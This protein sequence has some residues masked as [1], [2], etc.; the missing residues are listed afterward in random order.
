MTIATQPPLTEFVRNKL[1]SLSPSHLEIHDDSHQHIG[2][3]EAKAGA[4][5]RVVIV[6]DAFADMP[7]L[8]RHRL[9]QKTIGDYA[10]AG[11]HAMQIA[12][13]APGE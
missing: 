1:R 11:I 6:A 3:A 7:K 4:H 9:V 13:L 12:A 10:A 5:L 2:H 8:A